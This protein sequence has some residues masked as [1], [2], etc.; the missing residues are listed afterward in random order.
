MRKI[1]ISSLGTGQKRDGGYQKAKYSLHDKK[2]IETTFISKALQEFLGIDDVFLV[3]TNGSIW[4]SCYREFGGKDEDIELNLLAKIDNK[5]LN[6]D[7]LVVVNQQMG[8]NSKSFLIDYGTNEKELWDNFAKYLSILEHIQDGDIVYVDISHAFRSLALMSFLMVQFGLGVKNK[9]FTIGGIY[10]GMLE[11]SRE[12]KGITPI[13]DLKMFYDLMEWIKAIEAFKNY[14]HADLMVKLFEN[15][16]GLE[17]QEK[18]IFNLFDLNLSLANM[19][20][21]QKFIEN[22]QRVLPKLE[23]NNNPIIRLISPD[24]REFVSRMNVA[25]QSKFQFELAS[26]FYENKNYALTYTVLV[27]AL[28]T[29]QCENEK[30]NSKVK[31]NREIAKGILWKGKFASFKEIVGIRN[32]IAHQRDSKHT[33]TKKNVSDLKDYLAK[34][35]Q[36]ITRNK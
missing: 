34:A 32:D 19:S 17:H 8:N 4:D 23:K 25:P 7:D 9:K 12:N 35:K 16:E 1:L 6:Q 30:M 22:A 18:D 28:V 33:D 21:L 20:A 11:V 14:G 24:I 3:G 27:E 36:F 26:W 29:K 5:S 15:Q 13:V 31:E 2:I 10:Y